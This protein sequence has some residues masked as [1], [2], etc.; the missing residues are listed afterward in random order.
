MHVSFPGRQ[1]GIVRTVGITGVAA[2][3]GAVAA[4]THPALSASALAAVATVMS[5]ATTTACAS[6]TNTSSGPGVAASSAQGVA[7]TASGTSGISGTG[8]SG[9]GV[10][11]SST[12]GIA[13]KGT[14][15]SSYGVVG[16]SSTGTAGVVGTT[17]LGDGEGVYGYN[18]GSESGT[19]VY[20]TSGSGI[21]IFG[22]AA[23][24][25][26]VAGFADNAGA[27]V[28]G[29][30]AASAIAI[31]ATSVS[32][33]AIY[34]TSRNGDGVN[35]YTNGGKAFTG[36]NSKGQGAEFEGTNMGLIVRAEA[37]T[38][39]LMTY[40]LLVTDQKANNLAYVDGSGDI[41]YTGTLAKITSATSG[42]IVKSFGATST[43]PTIEDIGTAQLVSGAAVVRLDPTFAASIDPRV[44]YRV[45][46][47]PNGD[48]HTLYV[49]N[50]TA[51]AFLV[52][53]AQG[54]RSTTTFD[55]RIVATAFGKAGTRMA[56]T[57]A[58]TEPFAPRKNSIAEFRTLHRPGA[59][60][61]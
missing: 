36:R 8:T 17:S 2:V 30:A 5:C 42:K 20:G 23:T 37:A 15:G 43:V 48:T 33:T 14:S 55:Y 59:P 27:A 13:V 44:P 53:E 12:S 3:V 7:L 4:A 21:G 39:S 38:P 31:Y 46:I 18:S 26:G 51:T 32:G 56:V 60:H 35:S 28:Y 29:D 58:A 16:T 34:V 6:F 25:S 40:P 49:P 52:R 57:A 50:K 10:A 54:G 41:A 1:L 47:T 11:G 45:F 19:G 61:R 22:Q 9:Y 24:G